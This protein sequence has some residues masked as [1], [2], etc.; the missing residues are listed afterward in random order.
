MQKK[1]S[2]TL[3]VC[4]TDEKLLLPSNDDVLNW[5][6]YEMSVLEN[7]FSIQ[8][9]IEENADHLKSK[10]LTYIYDLGE[11]LING[12]RVVDHLELRP[13]FSYWW[14]TLLSEKCNFAK[15]PQI[16]NAIK[17]L[18][19]QD[20]LV[21]KE[22]TKIKLVS[23]NKQLAKAIRLFSEEMK[24]EFSWKRL[25]KVSDNQS[26]L[27]FFFH[28]LPR[29]IKAI[30]SFFRHLIIHWPL[31]GIGVVEWKKSQASTLFVSYFCNLKPK[32]V[33][34]GS[35]ES[36]YWESLP[37]M[38]NEE[39]RLSNWLHIYVKDE[40]IKNTKEA[41][42]LIDSFN[43]TH[44][45][46]QVHV[47]LHSFLSIKVIVKVVKDWLKLISLHKPLSSDMKMIHSYLWPLIRSDFHDSLLGQQSLIN[48]LYL[49]LFES[50][51]LQVQTQKIGFYLQENQ[52]WEFG[53]IHAWNSKGHGNSLIGILHSTVRY[54]DLR[55]F[56]SQ[57]SYKRKDQCDLP[58]PTY[59]GV[60]GTAAKK[61]Y[62]SGR[63]PKN[64]LIEIEA[65]RYLYLKDMT[66]YRNYLVTNREETK[67]VLIL[68]DYLKENTIKL[69]KLLSVSAQFIDKSI[70]Y[71]I[72]PHP[73]CPIYKE[74]YPELHMVVSSDPIHVLIEQCSLAYTSSITS[75]AVDAYCAGKHIVTILNPGALNLSPLK[76]YEGVTF[77]INSEE[78]VQAIN[79]VTLQKQTDNQGKDFFYIDK[80]L[81]RWKK[82]LSM[83]ES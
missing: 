74:D 23:S 13:G 22:Y 75:A 56:F 5:Q 54:W 39:G 1:S 52:G 11:A 29:T 38:L 57:E 72:K 50:A 83:M 19:L 68:G 32:A 55:Y 7:I 24:L 63:Y 37:K 40:L 73:L 51:M 4:D 15:S 48:L 69:M 76:G 44:E 31:K 62:L 9:L 18:A 10:Y 33:N 26:S 47:T 64:R 81:P 78:L 61:M 79:S 16:D 67:T 35:F 28:S 6:S 12:K 66:N 60:N 71:I 20:W 42:S 46:S 17:I 3:L 45:G 34:K 80:N 36:S 65:L 59:V 49:N 77:V 41:A 27:N 2:K 82:M 53:F 30:V 8:Q 43:K 14:M 70:K 25:I 21:E 58:L